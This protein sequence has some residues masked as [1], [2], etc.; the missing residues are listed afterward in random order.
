LRDVANFPPFLK[1]GRGRGDFDSPILQRYLQNS[2]IVIP[3]K[4]G[5][6]VLQAFLDPGLKIDRGP[7]QEPLGCGRV[8]NR[9][10]DG[11]IEFCKRLCILLR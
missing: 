10:G 1:G 5:I 4:A 11:P 2:F 6:Q 3:A 9:R 7:T 8:V